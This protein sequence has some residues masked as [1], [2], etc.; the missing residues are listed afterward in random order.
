[1]GTDPGTARVLRGNSPSD[2]PVSDLRNL[3][4]RM[5]PRILRVK[6]QLIDQPEFDTS[7]TLAGHKG[8]RDNSGTVRSM[9]AS[10]LRGLRA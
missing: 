10:F 5:S 9:A 8:A 1:L 3:G 7:P 4:I 6:D 2:Q